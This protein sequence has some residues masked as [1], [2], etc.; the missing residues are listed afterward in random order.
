MLSTYYYIY[1]L[2]DTYYVVNGIN[3]IKY[4]H[5]VNLHNGGNGYYMSRPCATVKGVLWAL[6]AE[7][8]RYAALFI[9]Y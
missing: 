5:T 8:Y 4:L 1:I 9:R 2:V 7:L 6:Q 3:I